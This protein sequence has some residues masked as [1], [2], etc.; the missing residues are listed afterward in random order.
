MSNF[1]I[2]QYKQNLLFSWSDFLTTN[3]MTNLDIDLETEYYL[4]I[5]IDNSYSMRTII[6]SISNRSRL[7]VVKD[8][9]NQIL[10]LLLTMIN[11]GYKINLSIKTFN[12][13]PETIFSNPNSINKYD[14]Q[15]IREK[16]NQI[17]ADKSTY[18]LYA[19]KDIQL[20]SSKIINKSI[21]ENKQIKLFRII[22][23]DGYDTSGIQRDDLLNQ[24]DGCFE[25]SLGIG[26]HD[27]Y[28]DILLSKI[29]INK[30]VFGSPSAKILSDNMIAPIFQSTTICA[31][32]VVITS[33]IPLITNINVSFNQN[34]NTYQYDLG[35]FQFYRLFNCQFNDEHVNEYFN[36]NIKWINPKTKLPYTQDFVLLKSSKIDE[37]CIFEQILNLQS[38]IQSD[39]KALEE[40]NFKNYD[41]LATNENNRG[42][43]LRKYFTSYLNQIKSIV[44]LANQHHITNEHP[45]I[46][47]LRSYED[48]INKLNKYQ[49]SNEYLHLLRT[50]SDATTYMSPSYSTR[51]SEIYTTIDSL[52]PK[53]ET[54]LTCFICGN[55]RRQ[56]VPKFDNII[57]RV[58]ADNCSHLLSC[59]TCFSEII[60][61]K[62]KAECPICRAIISKCYEIDFPSYDPIKKNLSC[63]D[64]GEKQINIFNRPCNHA[65]Y[66]S[67]CFNKHKGLICQVNNCNSIITHSHHFK[68][69]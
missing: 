8:T 59:P 25:C 18:M 36:I 21:N 57:T 64:C 31:Q 16:I 63:I 42:A 60:K 23:S 45:L 46:I 54:D 12:T 49:E 48:E 52:K 51:L 56:V 13:Q 61:S 41:Y 26:N 5:L 24:L 44:E 28:D 27:N 43:W 67:K 9:M 53:Q 50:A 17:V 6:D 62:G 14:I 33:S 19:I 69:A 47:S 32:N 34:E 3:Q 38:G 15:I 30:N 55:G 40:D 2:N 29:S 10:D 7:Q 22:L 11:Q 1:T 35:D 68:I 4:L 65:I 66:C 58:K 39:I 20:E 37:P